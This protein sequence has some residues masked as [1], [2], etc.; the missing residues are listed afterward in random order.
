MVSN[1]QGSLGSEVVT[2]FK[3]QEP[4]P[5]LPSNPVVTSL[6]SGLTAGQEQYAVSGDFLDTLNP[7]PEQLV[8]LS[9]LLGQG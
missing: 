2:R 1:C 7:N 8:P 9:L 6:V 5:Y 3:I 4:V